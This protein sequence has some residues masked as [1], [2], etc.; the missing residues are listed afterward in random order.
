MAHGAVS[1]NL[2]NHEKVA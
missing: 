2:S 1:H